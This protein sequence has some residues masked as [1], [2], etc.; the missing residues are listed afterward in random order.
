ML[1]FPLVL[2]QVAGW[3]AMVVL[4]DVAVWLT[5]ISASLGA[6]CAIVMWPD[7]QR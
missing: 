7:R 5:A 6:T 3:H 1:S 2:V 4:P